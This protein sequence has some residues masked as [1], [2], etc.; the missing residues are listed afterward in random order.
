MTYTPGPP[1]GAN[2]TGGVTTTY[3]VAKVE[4]NFTL[5][6]PSTLTANRGQTLNV[7]V[8]GTPVLGFAPTGNVTLTENGTPI[9]AKTL[10][11]G[12]SHSP[13]P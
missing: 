10:V 6:P 8:A 1:N 9:E 4:A 13:Y 11:G 3:I 7:S 5:D 12:T 2:F